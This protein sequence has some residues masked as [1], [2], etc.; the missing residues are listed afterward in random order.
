[1]QLKVFTHEC[2]YSVAKYLGLNTNDCSLPYF[3]FME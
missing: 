2:A 1:M 3:I